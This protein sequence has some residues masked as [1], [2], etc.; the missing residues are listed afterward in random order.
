M[1]TLRNRRSALDGEYSNFGYA[2]LADA[3]SC[4]FGMPFANMLEQR[5]A[6]PLQ[7]SSLATSDQSVHQRTQGY[8]VDGSP[9]QH[10]QF[11]AMVGAGGVSAATDDLLS[12]AEAILGLRRSPLGQ[13]LRTAI[14]PVVRAAGPHR[15]ALGWTVTAI[16]GASI[17]WCAGGLVGF[18]SFIGLHQER[19]L[20]LVAL[21]N[22]GRPVELVHAGF[23][24]MWQVLRAATPNVVNSKRE[25]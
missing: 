6:R 4:K 24:G 23:R 10:W 8:D 3:L 2:I 11:N 1:R 15:Y 17:V 9:A 5:L 14:T 16:N 22:S 19:R 21:M 7:L 18:S 13:A 25:L 12:L 20:P